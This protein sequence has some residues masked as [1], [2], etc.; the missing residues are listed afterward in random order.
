MPVSD[1]AVADHRAMKRIRDDPDNG[2]LQGEIN[3]T[4]LI[5]SDRLN[6]IPML[7]FVEAPYIARSAVAPEMPRQFLPQSPPVNR[8]GQPGIIPGRQAAD[9][10]E[11]NQI[12]CRFGR[13]HLAPLQQQ[14]ARGPE[15]VC[16]GFPKGHAQK[17]NQS[18]I[19][20]RPKAIAL[21]GSCR[22]LPA[23]ISANLRHFASV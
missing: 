10:V 1:S 7:V 3:V 15:K 23:E 20:I 21:Q 16:G 4:A 12:V 22:S 18:A 9:P 19:A 8:Q 13:R 17:M 14:L 2:V 5:T 6:L 11:S